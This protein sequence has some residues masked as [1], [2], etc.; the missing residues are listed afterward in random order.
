LEKSLPNIIGKSR[1]L[2]I[3]SPPPGN[4]R[5]ADLQFKNTRGDFRPEADTSNLVFKTRLPTVG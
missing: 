1:I 5:I 3:D 4:F 2:K